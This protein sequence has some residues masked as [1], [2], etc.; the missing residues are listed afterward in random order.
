MVEATNT[1]DITVTNNAN[2]SH[3]GNY[4]LTVTDLTTNCQGSDVVSVTSTGP[5][6]LSN[7]SFNPFIS[8]SGTAGIEQS[9]EVSG[10]NLTGEITIT[11]P[12]GYEISTQSDFSSNTVIGG[13]LGILLTPTAGSVTSTTLYIRLTSSASNGASG[14]IILTSNGAT[15]VSLATGPATVNSAPTFTVDAGS[16]INYTAGSTIAFDATVNGLSSG[17]GGL[18]WYMWYGKLWFRLG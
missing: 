16:D 17:G 18:S 15:T 8:C 12:I 3:I 14:N 13:S 5:V 7:P 9:F 2:S 6:I 1:E 10:I 11:P 4:T